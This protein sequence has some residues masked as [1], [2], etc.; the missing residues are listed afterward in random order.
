M[1]KL[2]LK[3]ILLTLNNLYGYA[4]SEYLPYG[5]FKWVK[6]TN[7]TVNRILNKKDNSLHGYFLEVDLGYPENLHEEH[8]DYPM[9]PEKIKIKTEWLSPYSLENA[10]K[11]DIKT[12][13]INKLAPN[14]MSKNN[15][16][17]H[18]R[19]LQYYLSQGLILKKVHKIL[20]FKQSAWMK[21]YID[22]N[23]QKRKEATNE[24][25]KNLFKLLNNAV[26]GKTMENMRKR[27]KIRITTNEKDFLKYASTPTY[28]DHKKFDKNLVVINEKKELLTLNKPV[29]VG[30]TVLELSK[31]EM[32]KFN[33]DFVKKKCKK[34]IL[35]FTDTD[36]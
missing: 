22:F 24:A 3:N 33:Y 5:G 19:N 25:N 26:Y 7:E 1:I 13:N 32:Y 10:N 20:E 17:V 29:Y 9:A 2:N 15:Y 8:S 35:L 31:L 28:I 16:V 30:C 18:Y 12:G 27:T 23:T 36:S 21:P 6:T 14:L 4:M 34:C 11:F